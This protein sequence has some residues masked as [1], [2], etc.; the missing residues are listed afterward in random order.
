MKAA[1]FADAIVLALVTGER[2]LGVRVVVTEELDNFATPSEKVVAGWVGHE[3]AA[4]ATQF[5]NHL[6]PLQS[7][8]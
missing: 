4:L 3:V 7:S 5:F 6:S 1:R 8:P 2:V